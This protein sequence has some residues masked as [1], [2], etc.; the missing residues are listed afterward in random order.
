M[1][2]KYP[3]IKNLFG[4][5]D[6]R[7]DLYLSKEETETLLQQEL[8]IQEKLDGANV[9]IFFDADKIKFITRGGLLESKK[10]PEQFKYL[11]N[12]TYGRYDILREILEGKYILFGEWLYF[13]HTIFYNKLPSYF[14]AF[15]LYDIEKQKFLAYHKLKEIIGDHV[16][17]APVIFRG[18]IKNMKNLNKLLKRKSFFGEEII[19]GV[20]LREEEGD[21][22]I[23]IY[24]Y[25][26]KSFKPG[27]QFGKRINL[28]RA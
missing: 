18:V 6:S 21:Y 25:K 12:W 7:N 13:T 26:R 5:Q 23:K 9:G 10:T 8:L 17:V 16:T 2:L 1:M 3:R 11:K 28:L 19:E 27:E 4:S 20:I 14:I 22:L 24:K 15:D